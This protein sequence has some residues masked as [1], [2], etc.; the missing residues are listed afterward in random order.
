MNTK[1]V[2]W[3][4]S[5]PGNVLNQLKKE[6][7]TNKQIESQVRESH[8]E[9]RCFKNCLSFPQESDWNHS[10]SSF[11]ISSATWGIE[12]VWFSS[13]R[14]KLGIKSLFSFQNKP[15][16]YIFLFFLLGFI[17]L[18]LPKKNLQI[19]KICKINKATTKTK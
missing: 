15:R 3:L 1:L 6:I 16:V 11:N 10:V 8:E 9:W 17:G 2:W 13:L 5:Q 7:K 14:W 18:E 19:T 4:N 12:M